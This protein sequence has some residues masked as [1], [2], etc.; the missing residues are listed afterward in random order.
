[1]QLSVSCIFIEN[2]SEKEQKIMRKRGDKGDGWE[3]I[4][5]MGREKEEGKNKDWMH[6]NLPNWGIEKDNRKLMS[7]QNEDPMQIRLEMKMGLIN[8]YVLEIHRLIRNEMNG[9]KNNRVELR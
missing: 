2:I 4:R 9:C 6:N 8:I 1:M 5:E 7:K 3:E